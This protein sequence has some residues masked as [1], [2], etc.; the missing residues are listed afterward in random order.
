MVFK[1]VMIKT[2]KNIILYGC[3]QRELISFK[4]RKK[5]ETW[6]NYRLVV[7]FNTQPRPIFAYLYL[8]SVKRC[9]FLASSDRVLT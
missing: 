2:I 9:T 4:R 5:N 3:R 6:V 7:M 1:H 8:E